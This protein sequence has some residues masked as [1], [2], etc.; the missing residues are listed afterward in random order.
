MLRLAPVVPGS[1]FP[2]RA[3]L[4][5]GCRGLTFL[6]AFIRLQDVQLQVRRDPVEEA[7]RES[8]YEC[9][10]QRVGVRRLI[11]GDLAESFAEHAG[12][13]IGQPDEQQDA[14][15]SS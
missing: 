10:T 6:S 13:L 4:I 14:R 5:T 3:G 2:C 12:V 1:H 11:P 9:Q 7:L 15:P 8:E